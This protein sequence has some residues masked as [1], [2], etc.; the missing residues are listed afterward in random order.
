MLSARL[1]KV[2]EEH[3]EEL[4]RGVL[5]D[6]SANARTPHYHN[7]PAD[8]L[9]RRVYDVYHNLGRWLSDKTEEHVE[10]TVSGRAVE[11]A[12]AAPVERPRGRSEPFLAL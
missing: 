1:V 11:A 4:T 2:I 3:A 5:T 10:A 6:L 7:L 9:H 8:E 12:G